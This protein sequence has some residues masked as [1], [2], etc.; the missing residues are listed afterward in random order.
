MHIRKEMFAA[1]KK[2]PTSN[3]I[4]ATVSHRLDR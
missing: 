3:V 4:P 2:A 1:Q